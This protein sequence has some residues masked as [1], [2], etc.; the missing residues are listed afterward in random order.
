VPYDL[1]AASNAA[2]LGQTFADANRSSKAS[3]AIR[4]LA[5]RVIGASDEDAAD[6]PAGKKSLL[7][8]FDFKSLLAKKDKARAKANA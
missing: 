5:E 3:A 4:D 8:S 2:K 7:G 1:K 6:T